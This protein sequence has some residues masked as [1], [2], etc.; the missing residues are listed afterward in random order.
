LGR[1]GYEHLQRRC[2]IGRSGDK[3][4]HAL[5]VDAGQGWWRAK[6]RVDIVAV[7][8]GSPRQGGCATPKEANRANML[9]PCC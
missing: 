6:P 4:Q 5:C 9:L 2:A 1:E 8:E 3:S 7:D